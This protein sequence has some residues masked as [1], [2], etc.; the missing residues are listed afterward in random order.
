MRPVN[1]VQFCI[2]IGHQLLRKST[3]NGDIINECTHDSITSFHLC[4]LYNIGPLHPSH[5]WYIY[6]SFAKM[7]HHTVEISWLT[8][9][10]EYESS[11]WNKIFGALARKQM[12]LIC[13]IQNST[14]PGQLSTRSA[15]NALALASVSFLYCERVSRFV[16][17]GGSATYN[18]SPKLCTQLMLCCVLLWS[19]IIV[20]NQ[21]TH[22]FQASFTGTGAII[23]LPQCQWSN[24][25]ECG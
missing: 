21:F 5:L 24:P 2:Q 11:V 12:S 10:W 15:Q 14:R 23:W 4:F 13:S 16:H 17:M 7:C 25:E 22:I 9:L 20:I 6:L 1:H 8:F 3:R 18:T 19:W